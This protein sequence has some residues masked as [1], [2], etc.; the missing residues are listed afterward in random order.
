MRTAF[1]IARTGRPGPVVDRRAEGRAELDRHVPGR[2]LLADPRLPAAARC[3]REPT[4]SPTIAAQQFFA[5][6]GESK[7][8]LI[9][10]GGGVINGNASDVAA[11]ARER[12]QDSRDH[13][14]DGPRRVRHDATAV[15][16]HARHA[17]HCERE[18]RRRRLRSSD[19]GRRALRRSRRGAC[20]RSSRRRR[21]TCCT[22]TSIRPRSTRSRKPTG[23][24]WACSAASARRARRVRPAH[25]VQRGL[26][27]VAQRDRRSEVDLPPQLRP[28]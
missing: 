12:V 28:R 14:A 10:A 19:R 4:R 25:R 17:R 1:E 20:R 7:R 2:Q 24:T 5:M 9:Y 16:A 27:R 18:L 22:S 15:A 13:H 3:R 8:P 6:L 23:T 26:R 11:R 21:S